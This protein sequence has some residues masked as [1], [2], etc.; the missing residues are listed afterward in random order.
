[1]CDI[2][3]KLYGVQP[4]VVYSSHTK[5]MSPGGKGAKLHEN[6]SHIWNKL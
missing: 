6:N 1:M 5:G 4:H 2:A 3:I